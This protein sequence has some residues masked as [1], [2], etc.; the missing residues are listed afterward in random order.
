MSS[1]LIYIHP[2]VFVTRGISNILFYDTIRNKLFLYKL[3]RTLDGL[4]K[5]EQDHYVVVHNSDNIWSDLTSFLTANIL[6]GITNR[7]CYPFI[8]KEK[9]IVKHQKDNGN[10]SYFNILSYISQIHIDCRGV[11]AESVFSSIH[12]RDNIKESVSK[13]L[14]D[15][16][17][18]KRLNLIYLTC[19]SLTSIEFLELVD[20]SISDHIN[21]DIIFHG[22]TIEDLFL[23][24]IRHRKKS[25][26]L[27]IDCHS[28]NIKSLETLNIE[29][30]T[31]VNNKSSYACACEVNDRLGNKLDILPG[32]T[33]D[34]YIQD[35]CKYSINDLEQRIHRL[36]DFHIRAKI[37]AFYWGKIYINHSGEYLSPEN[38]TRKTVFNTSIV[39]YSK[40]EMEKKGL[41][42]F[43]RDLVV[44]CKECA[45]R[46]LCPSISSL[47]RNIAIYN[48][49][50]FGPC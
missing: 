34:K 33:A 2:Y 19:D 27:A 41:W 25:I 13:W 30:I 39:E 8:S 21:L 10:T 3:L 14:K 18:F 23:K 48:L 11:F 5:L 6:G 42:F 15:I 32:T 24:C 20:N 40:L 37:N 47:E 38:S 16:C 44:P 7:N 4:N 45:C 36:K 12:F 28:Y 31:Y 17:L 9:Y 29:Y 49:C 22:N 46:Y 35:E 1:S 26:S 43:T 50:T